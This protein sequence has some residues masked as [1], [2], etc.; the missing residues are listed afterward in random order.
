MYQIHADI[1]EKSVRTQQNHDKIGH[2]YLI[3][4]QS[5]IVC[6][7]HEVSMNE[8]HRDISENTPKS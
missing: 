3:L 5:Q 2:N 7:M 4:A 8:I 6:N 1:T